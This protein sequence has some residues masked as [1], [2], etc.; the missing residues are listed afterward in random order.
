MNYKEIKLTKY[1]EGIVLN[2]LIN[3]DMPIYNI[4]GYYIFNGAINE[5]WMEKA[6]S[7]AIQK[8]PA[9]RV[10]IVKKDNEFRQ[11]IYD[12]E[13]I[14]L[15]TFIY[16][17][18]QISDDEINELMEED[19]NKGFNIF[20]DQLYKFI[21]I[22][23]DENC[24]YLYV[25][26][27]HVIADSY[28]ASLIYKTIC[29]EYNSIKNQ[30]ESNTSE[31]N[32]EGY[33]KNSIEYF[34][35]DKYKK[36]IE[37]WN[38]YFTEDIVE[39]I[40][41]IERKPGSSLEK[42]FFCKTDYQNMKLFC[43]KHKITAM[44]FFIGMLALYFSRMQ[45]KD[46]I[47]IGVPV[48]NRNTKEEME[49]T[50][51]Y[52]N[53]IPVAVHIDNE[54]TF[55][56]LCQNIRA[57]L[58]K[59]IMYRRVSISDL[60][61]LEQNKK[62]NVYDLILSYEKILYSYSIEQIETQIGT[63]TNK[64]EKRMMSVF[65]RE[66]DLDGEVYIDFCYSNEVFSESESI[67]NFISSIRQLFYKLQNN[68][69]LFSINTVS[70]IEKEKI[71]RLSVNEW[72][73]E[74]V[75]ESVLKNIYENWRK[76]G[77]KVAVI[78]KGK[79][80]SYNDLW[81][82]ISIITAKLLQTGVKKGDYVVVS[83]ERSSDLIASIY[84]IIRV[85]A[86]FVPI[87]YEQPKNRIESIL[88]LIKADKLLTNKNSNKFQE[89]DID[90]IEVDKID[91]EPNYDY[92]E[93]ID[94]DMSA[95]II[96]TSG[97]TGVPKG[98]E[99]FHRGLSNIIFHMQEKYPCK[100]TDVFLFKTNITF[101]V[102]MDE[103]FR[104]S[105][106]AASLLI[107]QNGDE[108][109]PQKYIYPLSVV[110]HVNFVPSMLN[111]LLDGF[112]ENSIRYSN[113][114]KYLMIAGEALKVEVVDKAKNVFEHAEI[115]NLYG[116]TEATVYASEYLINRDNNP[117]YISIGKPVRN[118]KL[119]VVDKMNRLQHIGA[120][121]ELCIAG[122]GVAKGYF[123]SPKLTN[124]SFVF[125]PVLS[126]SCVYKT[127]DL[128]RMHQDGNIEYIGRKDKQVKVRGFRIETGDIEHAIMN[129]HE[130]SS[131]VVLIKDIADSKEIWAFFVAK[132]EINCKKLREFLT[133]EIPYYMI[134]HHLIQIDKIAL[135]A[136][137]KV[138]FKKMSE[139]CV[140]TEKEEENTE[141]LNEDEKYLLEMIKKV[142]KCTNIHMS[143]SFFSIGGD[144]IKAIEL[145]G[146]L[147][148]K[149]YYLRI[150]DIFESPIIGEFV[151]KIKRST[152]INKEESSSVFELS[153]IQQ[154]FFDK[155]LH[156]PNHYNQTILI[157]S[158]NR[159][160]SGVLQ[161]AYKE[162][163]EAHSSLRLVFNKY[164][165]KV[166]QNYVSIDQIKSN[167]YEVKCDSLES[168]EAQDVI[169][170]INGSF[171]IS[172]APLMKILLIKTK[173]ED[174]LY[175]CAHHL[176][177]DF[178]SW[179]IL[180][181]DLLDSYSAK[182]NKN[183]DFEITQ[184]ASYKQWIDELSQYSRKQSVLEEL[185][186]WNNQEIYNK[187]IPA[188]SDK[189]RTF[190]ESRTVKVQL[191]SH[192]TKELVAEI[193]RLDMHIETNIISAIMEAL[194]KWKDINKIT[195]LLESY[196]REDIGDINIYRTTGWFTNE[197]PIT[198]E[199]KDEDIYETIKY[200]QKIAD[201][202]K[203]NGLSYGVL[204][205]FLERIENDYDVL[206]N[207]LGEVDGFLDMDEFSICD[208]MYGN[209]VGNDCIK[210]GIFDFE[211]YI[212]NQMI[213]ISLEYS[214]ND[215][216]SNEI[217]DLLNCVK[218]NLVNILNR[219]RNINQEVKETILPLTETQ[220]GILFHSL[221]NNS[222]SMYMEI[223]D[224]KLQ[225]KLE[226]ALVEK[227]FA[228]L[229]D[230]Y[231]ILHTNILL[232]HELEPVQIIRDKRNSKI[233][234]TFCDTNSFSN[235]II[236]DFKERVKNQKLDLEKDSLVQ[237]GVFC[238]SDSES[239]IVF[240]FHHILADGWSF[241]QLLN[242]FITTY[243]SLKNNE[244]K[245]I[246]KKM[247]YNEYF[248]HENSLNR[249]V[250]IDYWNDYLK[251]YDNVIKIPALYADISDK[252]IKQKVKVESISSDISQRI[253]RVCSRNGITVNAFFQT[254]WSIML[255]KLNNTDDAVFGTVVS[256][257]GKLQ[258]VD[259]LIGTFIN[260]IPVRI[261]IKDWN[262]KCVDII[263]DI[264]LH[265][266]KVS[267]MPDCSL[268]EIL[269]NIHFPCI[270]VYENYPIEESLLDEVEL[271]DVYEETNYPLSVSIATE[272][273]I[274]SLKF[275]YKCEEYSEIDIDLIYGY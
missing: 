237:I 36:V 7:L 63:Y 258:S 256:T 78:E 110:T 247:S 140:S 88:Y 185:M 229:N 37:F 122:Q 3:L 174:Y 98:V 182:I 106:D 97:S 90:I 55:S 115:V 73:S 116:P 95:Y 66:F 268:G 234:I 193:N 103:I 71:M 44:H 264:Q 222:N 101:D 223:M 94:P 10:H 40:E 190:G 22:K 245:K 20:N 52:A 27:H 251:G 154:S 85:G 135:N 219:L 34:E 26:Y 194:Y 142:L 224:I 200:N 84:A 236:S 30:S 171:N 133:C 156:T 212:Q 57:D 207:Y 117:D 83:M 76:W 261:N 180:T 215:F 149:G 217:L 166:L 213:T 121:G 202:V 61:V 131:S 125:N 59:T 181:G 139:L 165:T 230:S 249:Q 244:I 112:S 105:Q 6:I 263:K 241:A 173:Q 248:V 233:A 151:K 68:E 127:G 8:T 49:I 38:E 39:E 255:L 253:R 167:I 175:L 130:I 82:K 79:E 252:V 43:K 92:M 191:D 266:L 113:K 12:K 60:N 184:T 172:V 99:V 65:I 232:N 196:G 246:E 188:S 274:Y 205:S 155:N 21:L 15:E 187:L 143:D 72:Q 178:V 48:L 35:S 54:L 163:L 254:A 161:D 201:S 271:V 126:D 177:V 96:F 100:N 228:I 2:Q 211:T 270:T 259:N 179:N 124:A 216:S 169:H 257:R 108:K 269:V 29:E 4:G 141:I 239:R 218:D 14:N 77:S 32:Y 17:N 104:F 198:F 145:L 19:F 157:K 42:M 107:M 31:Q 272:D 260:T 227:T 18:K 89:T 204:H 199:R 56:E 46:T 220:K 87:D 192:T 146:K 123:N 147:S 1:Q 111:A 162:L 159:I 69:Q 137:G 5:L 183:N 11:R 209:P 152:S 160:D 23:K 74:I 275:I 70:D 226:K 203:F 13:K 189:D 16:V 129:Y 134:P 80:L 265:I 238:I 210:K 120:K 197:Y 53:I 164:G 45:G 93:S 24:S 25:K 91:N 41:C 81:K 75:F 28:A 231:D 170:G 132:E 240:A 58:K 153:P 214:E 267:Q 118:T 250:S 51:L 206:F 86:V 176:I 243:K 208:I 221:K 102:S 144:S 109:E 186:V 67:S 33:V 225:L 235:H 195:M 114:V 64:Y 150:Y 242:D 138:D 62:N 168:Q 262:Q 128:V 50:A 47:I 273:S 158:K 148:K 136:S 119:F 9:L